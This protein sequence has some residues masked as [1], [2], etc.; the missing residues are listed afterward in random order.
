MDDG[1]PRK[2]RV[3]AATVPAFAAAVALFSIALVLSWW[4]LTEG[5]YFEDVLLPGA[6]ALSLTA[7]LLVALAPWRFGPRIGRPVLVAGAAMAALGGLYLLSGLWGPA[8]EA[9]VGDGQRVLLY[10]VIFGLGVGLCNLVAPRIH[11]A[12][13]PVL[14]AGGIAAVVTIVALITGGEPRDLFEVDGTLDYPLGYRNAN[15]AFLAIIILTASGVAASPQLPRAIRVAGVVTTTLCGELFLLSQ[16]RAALP[17][18]LIAMIVYALASPLRLRALSWLALPLVPAVVAFLPAADLYSVV[19]A[20]G[21]EGAIPEMNAAGT[22]FAIGGVASLLLGIAAL[23]LEPRLPGLGS[24]ST[25]SNRVI[26]RGIATVIVAAALGFTVAVGE[27]VAWISE[28]VDEFTTTGTPDLSERSS[29]FTFN[30]GS[31]R[32]DLWRVAIEGFTDDPVVGGGA[33]SFQYEF[34]RERSSQLNARDA[35][36]FELEL[37]SELGIAGLGLFAVFVVAVGMAV[38]RARRLG[39]SAASLAAVAVACAAYWVVHASVDWFWPYP[40]VTGP[41]LVL[42]GAACAPAVFASGFRGAPRARIATCAMLVMLA[43]SAVPTL[44]ARRY[45]D[46]ASQV[47]R[48]DLQQAYGDLERARTL[49]PLSDWPY[50]IEGEIARNVDDRDR[51]MAAFSAA[52]DKQ[53][54]EWAGR[55]RLAQLLATENPKL[56]REQ[57]V[58]AL[59]LNPLASEIRELA[60][61]LGVDP[62]AVTGVDAY[63][64]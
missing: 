13:L 26:G 47:W 24:T 37:L 49:N 44:L 58:I 45:V 38:T 11:L 60:E 1:P 23:A 33:G 2:P 55:Y 25:R 15:A 34:L 62:T 8:P 6:I 20:E 29:R 31:E 41:V 12:L 18:I 40:G 4:A 52:I 35:H 63:S 17:A 42:L 46:Q 56:A 7:A 48:T 50:L 22:A 27:P 30:A 10:A 32:Y 51:A 53:P 9:A 43:L 5:A 64:P 59:D 3:E 39:S 57:I 28:R 36:S 14:I 16:S 19:N 21:L 61:R 54:N